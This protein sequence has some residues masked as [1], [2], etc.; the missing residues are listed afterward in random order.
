MSAFS[1]LHICTG[2]G[3]EPIK[4]ARSFDTVT[5]GL[6]QHHVDLTLTAEQFTEVAAAC[7]AA[8]DAMTR[9]RAA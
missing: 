9:E 4:V 3:E 7:M 2:Y 1:S 6:G 5:V 8:A